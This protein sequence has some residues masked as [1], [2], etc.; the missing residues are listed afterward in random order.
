MTE[1]NVFRN[2]YQTDVG[3]IGDTDPDMIRSAQLEVARRAGNATELRCLLSMLGL[4]ET[5]PPP[6]VR[7]QQGPRML[8]PGHCLVCGIRT[9]RYPTAGAA[10][11]GG[12]GLCGQHYQEQ[13]R[14]DRKERR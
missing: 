2:A 1:T 11:Y 5:P 12:R 10:T 8:N 14:A 3:E 7:K 9:E 4:I 6:P 13:L